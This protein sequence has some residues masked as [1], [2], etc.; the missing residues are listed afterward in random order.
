[1]VAEDYPF[2]SAR[3]KF[4]R[5]QG[6]KPSTFQALNGTTKVVPFHLVQPG[7]SLAEQDS[8][9]GTFHPR[10]LRFLKCLLRSSQESLPFGKW[11]CLPNETR[12]DCCNQQDVEPDLRGDQSGGSTIGCA[13]SAESHPT[14]RLIPGFSRHLRHSGILARKRRHSGPR[15]KVLDTQV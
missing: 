5:P 8:V 6:L 3:A 1:M 10:P 7:T 9:L 12:Q 4:R 11:T 15:R 2:S 13:H 14:S